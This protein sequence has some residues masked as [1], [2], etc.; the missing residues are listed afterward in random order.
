MY[1]QLGPGVAPEVGE[2]LHTPSGPAMLSTA[3]GG[4]GEHSWEDTGGLHIFNWNFALNAVLH[5]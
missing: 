1:I 3:G 5:L 4:S 2:W